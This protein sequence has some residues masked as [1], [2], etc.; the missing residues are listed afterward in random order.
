M[1]MRIVTSL[2]SANFVFIQLWAS[3]ASTRT[4]EPPTCSHMRLDWDNRMSLACASGC[5]SPHLKRF[6]GST[7]FRPVFPLFRRPSV[8]HFSHRCCVHPILSLDSFRVAPLITQAL[9]VAS[10]ERYSW[11]PSPGYCRSLA[12]NFQPCVQGWRS[13]HNI[14]QTES[15]PP[16][17]RKSIVHP[18]L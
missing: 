14:I 18:G 17:F 2:N 8:L 15:L 1:R 3:Y 6:H 4:L 10:R 9:M 13:L 12:P 11:N 7:S 5:E 16:F